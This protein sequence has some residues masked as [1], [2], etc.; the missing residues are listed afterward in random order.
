MNMIFEK[1]KVIKLLL[2]IGLLGGCGDGEQREPQ[3][4][5]STAVSLT[6]DEVKTLGFTIPPDQNIGDVLPPQPGEVVLGKIVKGGPG[7]DTNWTAFTLVIHAEDPGE[8]KYLVYTQMRGPTMKSAG[9]IETAGGHLVG[10]QTWRDGARDELEQEA[11]I[12]TDKNNLVFLQIGKT[13][14]KSKGEPYRNANFFV[15]FKKR[16]K[17]LNNSDEVNKNY[18]H[19]WIDLKSLYKEVQ[20]EQQDKGF[21]V[22][23]KYYSFFRG[24]LLKFCKDVIDCQSL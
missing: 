22:H 2:I 15:V 24:H 20:A 19:Q 23:G 14:L 12:K 6:I 13:S 17:T 10:G 21:D 5:K 3:G 9:T 16:P 4:S 18:G 1:Y 8:K 11:G 7:S